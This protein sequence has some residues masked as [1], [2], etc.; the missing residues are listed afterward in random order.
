MPKTITLELTKSELD[1]MYGGLYQAFE[2]LDSDM[3][4][5]DEDK[6]EQKKLGKL[7]DRVKTL[8]DQE[9]QNR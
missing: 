4:L 8:L 6:A 7:R 1:T 3:S 2:D 9:E 5:D